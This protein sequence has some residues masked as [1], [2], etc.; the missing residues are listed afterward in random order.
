MWIAEAISRLGNEVDAAVRRAAETKYGDDQLLVEEALKPW[1][2]MQTDTDT[3]YFRN[4][5][6]GWEDGYCKPVDIANNTNKM[7]TFED[8]D[9]KGQAASILFERV[10]NMKRVIEN[11]IPNAKLM[12]KH[13]FKD[14]DKDFIELVKTLGGLGEAPK[15][16]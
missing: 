3:Y 4:A 14:S 11:S 9:K 5:V 7:L 15:E 10:M 2:E 13:I 8:L 12:E 1:L 6:L 16:D